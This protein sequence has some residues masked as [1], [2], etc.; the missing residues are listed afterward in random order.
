L[1]ATTTA[2]STSS[3]E[4]WRRALGTTTTAPTMATQP[5]GRPSRPPLAP[6]PL[7]KA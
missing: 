6:M 1:T 4:W 5:G 3:A 2:S 7:I